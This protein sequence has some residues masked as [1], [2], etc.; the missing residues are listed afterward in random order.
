MLLPVPPRRLPDGPDGSG[1]A[2][3]GTHSQ[4]AAAVRHWSGVTIGAC[5]TFVAILAALKSSGGAS[6]GGDDEPWVGVTLL[7]L[8]GM[9]VGIGGIV[10]YWVDGRIGRRGWKRAWENRSGERETVPDTTP[11]CH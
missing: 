4:S 8:V 9:L 11:G 7:V 1:V 6:P 2:P 3:T 10:G 5:A